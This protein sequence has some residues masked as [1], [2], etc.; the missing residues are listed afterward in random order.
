M[1][2]DTAKATVTLRTLT[3]KFDNKVKAAAPFYPQI[4][5]V[6][7][8]DGYDEAYG[9]LG[10]VPGVREWLGDRQFKEL[11]AANFS[12]VNKHWESSLLIKKTDIKDDRMG[13]YGPLMEQLAVEAAHHPDELVL[14]DLLPNGDAQACFDGQFFFDTDH[15]W[16]DSGSQSNDLTSDA[17]DHTAVTAAEFRTAYHA[18]RS[19]MLD[20]KNDQGKLLNRPVVMGLSSLLIVVPTELELAAYTGLTAP[21]LGGDTNVVIDRPRIVVCPYLTSAV[22]FYVFNTGGIIK[23]FIFQAREP[24]SRQMK[25]LDDIEVKDVKFMTEAR[26]NV[27]YGAWWTG[28]MTTFN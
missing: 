1:A 9:M 5:T 20:F 23:P 22:E 8:S 3:Q 4:C 26:Y 15:S 25:G 14:S 16:G 2:L 17:T 28:V 6:V 13:L 27:G 19:A 11:R 24:L 18:A 10:N 21:L 7:P 12:I